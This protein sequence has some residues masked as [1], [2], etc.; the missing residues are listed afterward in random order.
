MSVLVDTRCTIVITEQTKYRTLRRIW[1]RTMV[2]LSDCYVLRIER[3][4]GL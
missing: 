4:I 3:S 2:S 1:I